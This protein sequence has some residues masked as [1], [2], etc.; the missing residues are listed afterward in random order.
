MTTE[1]GTSTHGRRPFE[2]PAPVAL[3]KLADSLDAVPHLDRPVFEPKWDGYRAL[4]AGG[5]L[6][7]RRGTDLT[8]YFPDLAPVLASRLPSDLVLDGE[9]VAWDTAAGRLDFASLQARLTAGNRIASVAARRPAQFVA[10]DILAADGHDLRGRPLNQRRRLLEKAL[11][12]VAAP[13]ALCQQTTDP[14]LARE[15]FNTLTA[16]GIEGLV[17]K[18]TAGSYPTRDGQR[19]WWKVKAR[20]T[21]DMVAIGH[22]G[23][24][25]A[26]T[27][28]VLAFPGRLADDGTPVTAGSTTTL[29]KALAKSVAPL[30]SPTGHTFERIFAWG[31][32]EPTTVHATTPLVVEVS[33]DASA[34]AGA[35]RHAAKLLR[36]R[37]DLPVHD[38]DQ[39]D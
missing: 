1:Q 33:A 30:L 22:T 26:P 7:S 38:L 2:L 23:P 6:Y 39:N 31:A 29:T 32:S 36:A 9:I 24:A 28:L 11:S 15:W 18:D 8:R 25:A 12:G 19:I 10:F 14:V 17:I 34:E 3:A 5:R 13:I 37:P 27:T 35:L 16:G 20:A 21:L 4:A